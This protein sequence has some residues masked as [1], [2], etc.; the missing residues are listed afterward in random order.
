MLPS[1][2]LRTKVRHD[3]IYPMLIEP[4]DDSIELV[5]DLINVFRDNTGKKLGEMRSILEEMEDQGFDY[6]LVRG[7]VALLE[8]RS[9]LRVNSSIDP[10][11]VRKA[12]FSSASRSYP[13]T[14][15]EKWSVVIK[16]AAV[17]LG[18]QEDEVLSS[19][20][21]DLENEL[22][23]ADFKQVD[24]KSL[25]NEYNISLVQSLLFKATE[26]RF[27][28]TGGHKSLLR[29]AKKMGLM[30]TAEQHGDRVE[31]AIDGPTSALKMTERYGTL[32]ARLFPVIVLAP[33]WS[34][35]ASILRK[36]YSGNPRIYRL[37]LSEARSGW[38]FG[39]PAVQDESFDSEMESQFFN[40]FKNANTG[41]DIIREPE[42]LIAGKHIFIPDFLL[43][44][45]G[46]NVYV[47]IMG[48]WTSEYLK[49]KIGKL[50]G[51]K[52]RDMIVLVNTKMACDALKNISGNIIFY[53]KKIPLKP[54]MDS[55]NNFDSR[56]A[57]EGLIKLNRSGLKIDG[58]I[59]DINEA[60]KKEN[61]P[62][63]SIKKYLEEK[64]MPGYSVIGDQIVKENII[65]N[66][67]GEL[68]NLMPY[69]EA[70]IIISSKGILSADAVIK[71]LGYIVKWAGLDPES[72]ILYKK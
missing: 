46:I 36:D 18:V 49:R 51:I 40:I 23:L 27:S 29:N 59:I 38:L 37:K 57:E 60:S 72:A 31:I 53:D 68:K 48:F 11:K 47:E 56:L 42:P 9:E 41:W 67:K 15:P 5:S 44:K 26:L 52:G 13:V 64:V 34:L 43:S 70:V 17:E 21:A 2:L 7:L 16:E 25:I 12:V 39:T 20:Y 8:R 6:R 69:N 61:V 35:E 22:V 45:N 4:K 55:L 10:V 24:E 62:A 54:I 3:E 33:G 19:M 50:S 63:V 58:D 28:A 30:Y 71:S 1:D 32:F 66:I 65:E 14:S